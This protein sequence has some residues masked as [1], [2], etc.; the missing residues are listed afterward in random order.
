MV[1]TVEALFAYIYIY[2]YIYI[3]I[4][5]YIYIHKYIYTHC[6]VTYFQGNKNYEIV[7]ISP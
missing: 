4:Y 2:K 3:H 7:K 5:T 6:R 1:L